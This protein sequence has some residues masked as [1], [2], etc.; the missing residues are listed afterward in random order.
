MEEQLAARK[1]ER[2]SRPLHVFKIPPKLAAESGIKVIGIVELWGSEELTVTKRAH[3]DPAALAYE[4]TKESL[5]MV[6][7]RKVS[8]FDGSVDTLWEKLKP[9][10]R[11]L[12]LQAY[13]RVHQPTLEDSAAFLQSHEVRV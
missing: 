5:R 7:G 8:V 6:D 4:L 2:E 11:L 1:E 9:P 10:V 13:N 12:I 3:G